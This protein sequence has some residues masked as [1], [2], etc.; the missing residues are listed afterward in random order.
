MEMTLTKEH[1]CLHRLNN[2][3][4]DGYPVYF[5]VDYARR[6]VSLIYEHC[7]CRSFR[8]LSDLLLLSYSFFKFLK[9]VTSYNLASTFKNFYHLSTSQ[10]LY[11]VCCSKSA[12]D[13][14]FSPS[15]SGVISRIIILADVI[16]LVFQ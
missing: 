5:T 2:D 10:K 1:F 3:I 11:Y 9:Q 12:S 15:T 4:L 7:Y 13:F 8:F 6:V 16:K 14:E